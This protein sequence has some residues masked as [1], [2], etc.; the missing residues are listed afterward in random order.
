MEKPHEGPVFHTGTKGDEKNKKK[1]DEE[2]DS[3]RTK[4]WLSRVIP[5]SHLGSSDSILDESIWN[6]W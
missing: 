1:K 2:E 4:P 3:D 5:V 6:L